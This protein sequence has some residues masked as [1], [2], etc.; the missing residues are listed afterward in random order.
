MTEKLIDLINSV[1]PLT[2][3]TQR[4]IGQSVPNDSVCVADFLALSDVLN[5]VTRKVT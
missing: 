2:Q 3:M 5:S 4:I 1:I